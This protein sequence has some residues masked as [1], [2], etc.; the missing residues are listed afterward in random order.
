MQGQHI[1]RTISRQVTAL[2]MIGILML[3]GC[4]TTDLT[5]L[6]SDLFSGSEPSSS[7]TTTKTTPPASTST[8]KPTATLAASKL[9]WGVVS[10]RVDANGPTPD[11]WHIFFTGS[12]DNRNFKP[13]SGTM[14][15]PGQRQ[16]AQLWPGTYTIRIEHDGVVM[17]DGPIVVEAG[18]MVLIDGKYGYFKNTI[19]QSSQ[20]IYTEMLPPANKT[21]TLGTLYA[22][23]VLQRGNGWQFEYRGEQSRGEIRTDGKGIVGIRKEGEEI[24]KITKADIQPT[25]ISGT[26]ILPD[27]GETEGRINRETVEFTPNGKTTWITGKTFEGE[28]EAGVPTSGTLNMPNGTQWQGW[29][30]KSEPNGKGRLTQKDGRWQDIEN[31]DELASLTG[32]IPCGSGSGTATTCS[33]FHGKEVASASELNK[34]I[35]E[36][37]RLAEIERQ[38]LE[39]KRLEERAARAAL[40]EARNIAAAEQA[41]REAA[42]PKKVD[43]CTTATGKFTADGDLTTYTMNG[44]G[45]GSGHFRQYTYGGSAQYQ[46]DIDFRFSTTANSI[47]FQYDQGIYRDAS[48]GAVLQRTSIPG[49]SANCRFDGRILTIDGKD[50]LRN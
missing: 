20:T 28:Y 39:D 42:A 41:A 45:S 33:Y 29:L 27:G 12:T 3:T 10:F 22:P 25:E 50:F 32:T 34:L 4:Q 21:A 44:Q 2:P 6:G 47:S 26:F 48:S 16:I 7:T 49:G 40:E 14:L 5:Q 43:D 19:E 11:Y 24:V 35:T 31:Y 30:D 9:R 18:T 36:E 23:I 1:F 15:S 8:K 46:F 17:F 38:R 37:K 13:F